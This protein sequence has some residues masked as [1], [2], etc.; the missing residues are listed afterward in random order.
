[1][2][3]KIC[4]FCGKLFNPVSNHQVYCKGPHMRI[5][6]ACGKDYEETNSKNLKRP[7]H[8]C[9]YECRAIL[10]RRT[11]IEKYGCLAP[12]NN[13]N[14]RDKAVSTM[15][16]KY[17]VQYA[18]Q[19]PEIRAKSESTMI[20]K[21]GVRNASLVP[22]FQKKKS[23]TIEQKY[24][25]CIST[26]CTDSQGHVISKQSQ[27]FS[28]DLRRVGI[29]HINEFKIGDVLYDMC[30]PDQHVVIE[31]DPSYT[32][33][34][35]NNCEKCVA[36]SYHSNK[37]K[38]AEENGY[39]CIHIFDWDSRI[40]IINMLVPI[41]KH[42]YARNT[43]V[44]KLRESVAK[45]FLD[46]YHLQSSSNGQILCLGL[47]VN[48]TLYEVMTFGKSRHSKNNYVELLRFCTVPG[49]RVVGGASKLFSYA[50][51][52]FGLSKIITYC[53]R[54]KFTGRTYET[55]GMTHINTYP[56]RK[57]WS[58]ESYRMV[59]DSRRNRN[60]SEDEMISKGWAP[61]YDCGQ[62]VYEFE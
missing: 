53:D 61:V 60:I 18:M 1:M 21:Y 3:T 59:D 25:R 57:I 51:S 37:T 8:A 35:Y 48:D 33:S 14:A 34:I 54:S 13:K 44:Y 11:S 24:N 5:C 17:G 27:E 22:E 2:G 30:I 7:P 10:T 31:V 20:E 32:H 47:V 4:K 40:K 49:V 39:R 50:T 26:N 16:S 19:S 41:S 42:I 43:D 36:P 38:L 28:N 58:K 15:L 29:N 56:P 45:E 6:P 12:G 23:E 46:K 55:M 62:S 52:E 9:S